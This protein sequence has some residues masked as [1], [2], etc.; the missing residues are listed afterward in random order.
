[1]LDAYAEVG[2]YWLGVAKRVGGGRSVKACKQRYRRLVPDSEDKPSDASTPREE[3]TS[4]DPHAILNPRRMMRSVASQC[5]VPVNALIH[6]D[7]EA[8]AITNALGT[9]NILDDDNEAIFSLFDEAVACVVV[10]VASSRPDA[11]EYAEDVVNEYITKKFGEGACCDSPEVCAALEEFIEHQLYQIDKPKPKKKP[12]SSAASTKTSVKRTGNMIRLGGAGGPLI[13]LMVEQDGVTGKET[14]DEEA[15]DMEK[16]LKHLAP[17]AA[18]GGYVDEDQ[19]L[20]YMRNCDTY[21]LV[22][23]LS[24]P[25]TREALEG[26][27]EST[28]T[29]RSVKD[30]FQRLLAPTGSALDD[31]T[32]LMTPLQVFRNGRW[33]T[34]RHVHEQPSKWADPDDKIPMKNGLSFLKLP[35]EI[36]INKWSAWMAKTW[37]DTATVIDTS[38]DDWRVTEH[39]QFCY[40]LELNDRQP[41]TAEQ[42]QAF[43]SSFEHFTDQW[44][45]EM[46][47]KTDRFDA[48]YVWTSVRPGVRNEGMVMARSTLEDWP[49]LIE[50][51][52]RN[53]KVFSAMAKTTTVTPEVAAYIRGGGRIAVVQQQ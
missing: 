35:S 14:V 17:I 9:F 46:K 3:G 40:G 31:F 12:A 29:Q 10:Q 41:Y 7:T 48:K 6:I 34:L 47:D 50:V 22:R 43:A 23:I 11:E 27:R 21:T 28:Q 53:P 24:A 30:N 39:V 44:Q 26:V 19:V 25:N 15:S 5:D 36:V 42:R 33:M 8:G 38:G 2:V 20:E 51:T 13:R 37:C 32:Y 18:R 16:V 45:A 4:L 52:G 1:M 49:I